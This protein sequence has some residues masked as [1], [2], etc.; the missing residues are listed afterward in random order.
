[1]IAATIVTAIASVPIENTGLRASGDAAVVVAG[2]AVLGHRV[3]DG[4][5]LADEIKHH[6]RVRQ[7]RHHR[8]EDAERDVARDVVPRRPRDRGRDETD[9]T[10]DRQR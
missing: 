5:S 7:Q 8:R 10:D 2:D 1:M 6:H 9:E 4:F 3:L